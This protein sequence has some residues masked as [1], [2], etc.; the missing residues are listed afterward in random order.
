V[1]DREQRPINSAPTILRRPGKDGG[2]V[3]ARH[4]DRLDQPRIDDAR[5]PLAPV[6]DRTTYFQRIRTQHPAHVDRPLDIS[7]FTAL[8]RLQARRYYR[9]YYYNCA[10]YYYPYDFWYAHYYVNYYYPCYYGR[11]YVVISFPVF[12]ER[13][14][15][16]DCC[17]RDDSGVWYYYDRECD[18]YDCRYPYLTNYPG[19]LGRALRDIQ[20]AWY[21]EEINYL[22]AHVDQREP[23]KIY[24]GNRYTHDLQPSEFVDLT[25]DAFDQSETDY[26]RYTEIKRIWGGDWA[27][28]HG[29]HTLWDA[30]GEKR[31]IYL[32]YLLERVRD[33]SGEEWMLREIRQDSSPF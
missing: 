5:R 18:G 17:P 3:I 10:P 23:I 14:H 20:R 1:P 19:T 2:E 29:E 27:R 4:F 13:Y 26:L 33:R 30:D 11:P 7:Y 22:F 15:R 21:D 32:S 8:H 16:V 6:P 25:L 24:R 28:V 31:K 9:V 12:I